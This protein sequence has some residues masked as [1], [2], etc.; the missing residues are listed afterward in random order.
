MRVGDAAHIPNADGAIATAGGNAISVAI[1]RYVVDSGGVTAEATW[2]IGTTCSREIAAAARPSRQNR[3]LAMS[4][5]W[6]CG[7]STLIATLRCKC[8]ST[9]SS[10]IPMPPRPMTRAIWN[11]CNFPKKAGSPD[12]VKKA[13]SAGGGAGGAGGGAAGVSLGET[14]HCWQNICRPAIRRQSI[15]LT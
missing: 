11:W 1:Q 3:C 15:T 12:G 5:A 14:G 4:L 6:N 2:Y 13:R 10:T 9:P 8:V 7:L